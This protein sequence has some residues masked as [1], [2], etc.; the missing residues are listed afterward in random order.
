MEIGALPQTCGGPE[1]P[2]AWIRPGQ[3][4]YVGPDLGV[5]LHS[6]SV[7]VLTVGLDAPFVVET[8]E[9]GVIRTRSV[10]APARAQHRVI[11]PEGR[12]LL[13][14]TENGSATA[15][16]HRIGPYGLGHVLE[17]ELIAACRHGADPSVLRYLG[18]TASGSGPGAT[19]R[20]IRRIVEEIRD[21]PA[22]I[23]RAEHSARDL[24]MSTPY[25]LRMFARHTGTTFRRYQQ[26][27][28]LLEAARGIA[29]GHP[30]T[31]CAADAGFA[32]PSHLSDTFHETLGTT[33]T[34]VLGSR[35][36]FEL[37]A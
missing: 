25:F 19:D 17:R 13:L 31:R 28:R 33:A 20:R 9:Y 32:S 26:W 10:Y 36:R 12:I 29:G 30:L 34:T 23:L 6:A 27:N 14:F 5:D 18:D 22:R 2:V 35:V 15:M 24:G 8:P 7:G 3:A 16:R 37:D 4:G 1:A 11:A 21:E